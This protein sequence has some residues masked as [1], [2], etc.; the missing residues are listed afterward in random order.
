MKPLVAIVGRPNVGKSRL[1]NRLT[2]SQRAIVYDFEGVTRDRQYGDAEW[3]GR[4][5]T[6][7]DTGGFEPITDEPLL[8]LMRVQAQ[9]AIEEADIIIFMMDGQMGLL[10]GDRE[11]AAR[12]RDTQKPIFHVVNKVDSLKKTDEMIADFYELG[13]D[14]YPSSAE[15]GHGLDNLMDHVAELIPRVDPD[16]EEEPPPFARIAVVGKPNA[17]KSSTINAMLGESRLLTSDIAGTT[18]D[19]VDTM[20]ERDGKQYQIIDTAGL[21]KKSAIHEKLE[22]F[23]VV[24]AIRSIDQADVALLVIDATEGVT[25][26]DKKIAAVVNNRGRACVILV[27]K[28]D[29]VQ[30]DNSTAGEWVKELRHQMPFIAWA[31]VIMVSALTTKR[32]DKILPMVDKVFEQYTSRVPTREVNEFLQGV[33]AKHSPPLHGN[34]RL[35][36]YYATQAATRPP[37]FVF[38]VNN[39]KGIAPSYR[40]FLENQI[41]EN[42]GFE[43]TPIKTIVR[44]RRRR[45]SPDELI[46]E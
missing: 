44:E 2:E 17:G 40:R 12:L 7:I 10:E 34:R 42:F 35:K 8:D 46:Y 15:H 41:R 43:G 45:E 39:P 26:Q 18:R 9:L 28:W 36:F 16:K 21:R 38:V 33:M 19:A 37:R 22:E 32:V 25:S 3:F 31:P 23:S 30:K 14:L 20:L 4:E 1:F 11:I 24:Q 29:L 5:Y 6:L 13:V 27:N